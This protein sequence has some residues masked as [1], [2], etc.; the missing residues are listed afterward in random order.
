MTDFKTIRARAARR[1]GGEAVLATLLPAV[2]P[3]AA[4]ADIADDRILSE[5][6]KR[7]FSA[8]FVWSVIE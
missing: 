8:G 2:P 4:L 5:M 6:A 3:Q 7:V 1:K